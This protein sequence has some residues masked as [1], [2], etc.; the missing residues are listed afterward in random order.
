MSSH[1]DA[2]GCLGALAQLGMD[3]VRRLHDAVMSAEGQEMVALTEAYCAAGRGVRQ[4]IAL[5]LRIES[6]SFARSAQRAEADPDA[7]PEELG[8]REERPE[9]ADWNEYE[10]PDW[11]TPL[12]LTGDPAHDEEAIQAAVETA[13]VKIRR[14]YAKAAAVLA[15]ERRP[16]G[17]AALLNGAAPLRLVDSS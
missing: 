11:E 14:S 10:R 5:R 17:R 8:D 7:E 15:P 16:T 4:S 2:V 3:V 9:R 12:R 13:V 1:D 6:G